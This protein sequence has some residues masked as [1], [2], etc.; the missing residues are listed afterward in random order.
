MLKSKKIWLATVL[1]LATTGSEELLAQAQPNQPA[2]GAAQPAGGA[3]KPGI[4]TAEIQRAQNMLKN[5]EPADKDIIEKYVRSE[6]AKL[7]LQRDAKDLAAYGQVRGR[8]CLD[9][10]TSASEQARTIASR[11]LLASAVSLKN[12]AKQN[13]ATRLNAMLAIAELDIDNKPAPEAFNELR[14]TVKDVNAPMELRAVA[15]YGLF[16]QAKLGALP[17]N[18]KQQLSQEMVALVASEP[19]SSLDVEPNAWIVRRG[20]DTLIALG[21]PAAQA[22]ALDRLVNS[23]ELP[24][25]RLAAA[26]YLGKLDVSKMNEE[27]KVK[28]FLGVMQFIE[29]QL[30][31]WHKREHGRLQAKSGAGAGGGGYGGYGGGGGKGMGMM[32]GSSSDMDYGSD[33]GMGSYDMSSSGGEMGSAGSGYGGYG[34]GGGKDS[35]PKVKPLDTQPWDVRLSRRLLNHYAQ[36]AHIALDGKSMKNPRGG[37]STATGKGLVNQ[38]LPAEYLEQAKKLVSSVEQLQ[39]R[40]NGSSADA[41]LKTMNTL[42]NQVETPIEGVMEAVRKLPAFMELYPEYKEN[43]ELATVEEAKSDEPAPPAGDGDKA[44]GEGDKP[45]GD[46]NQPTGEGDKPAGNEGEPSGQ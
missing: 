30:V 39:L 20:F 18:V 17:A 45:A 1:A 5:K 26:E 15:A 22:V 4:T 16:R 40:I 8:L 36:V 46:A 29:S 14:T 11:A 41:K 28:Y 10:R 38:G 37:A 12:N 6:M 44:A 13:K 42:L 7:T 31:Q 9:I 19:K 2:A 24:S 33:G 27:A 23:K 32:G 25:I 35:A 21:S 34:G 43:E 3:A